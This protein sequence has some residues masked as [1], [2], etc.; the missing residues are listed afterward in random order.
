MPVVASAQDITLQMEIWFTY[1]IYVK[2]P[3][4]KKAFSATGSTLAKLREMKQAYVV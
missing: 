4:A 2:S 1:C 3:K